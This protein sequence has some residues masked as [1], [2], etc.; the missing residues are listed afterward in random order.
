M[1]K[2]LYGICLFLFAAS[3][4]SAN[5]QNIIEAEDDH[6]FN[7][8]YE[9]VLAKS[10]SALPYAPLRESDVI[11]E[12]AIWRTIDFRESFNQFFF[13]PKDTTDNS[14][15]RTN[16]AFMI[17]KALAN[18]DIEAYE[19]SDMKVPMDWGV[20]YGKLNKIDTT[21]TDPI[22]D[23]YGEIIDEGHD[24]II[25]KSFNTEDYFKIFLKEFWYIDKQDSRQK[26]R[27]V[28]L[29][30]VDENC[31]TDAEG[32]TSCNPLERLWIPMDDMRVR[33]VFAKHNAYDDFNNSLERSYDEIFISRFF[34]SYITR[35]SNKYN[36]TIDSYL[37][38]EDAQLQS[39]AIEDRI[40][41]IESD[42]W[43]Y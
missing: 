11:W 15:G 19:T 39:M 38:G 29:C 1:K 27:I 30:L 35:E 31:K 34:E 26:V 7:D 25:Y 24:T 20:L 41:E 10:K 32:E 37:T 12:T 13:F 43:E 36:R 16:L 28:G 21:K 6:N 17:Y 2:V 22:Y 3:A 9:K 33:N 4:L 18:G 14:Q 40:F 42:M 23:D 5:A 8:Y